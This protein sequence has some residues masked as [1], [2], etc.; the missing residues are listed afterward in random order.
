MAYYG[1]DDVFVLLDGYDMGNEI[2]EITPPDIEA[3]FEKSRGFG[4]AWDEESPIGV[5]QWS[6]GFRARYDD[7][8]LKSNVAL[9]TQVGTNRVLA[10]GLEGNAKGKKVIVCNPGQGSYGRMPQIDGLTKVSVNFVGRDR[11]EDMLILQSLAADS[12]AGAM[13]DGSTDNTT[14][15]AN[16]GRALIVVTSLTLGGYTSLTVNLR[17]SSDNGGGDPFAT[18]QALVTGL[19]GASVP[20]AAIV[21]ISGTIE[22]YTRP[23]LTWNGAGSGESVTALVALI[24]D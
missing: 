15:S 11:I 18:K 7:A 8:A 17:E 4:D 22:R 10:M 21:P 2:F 20:Y 5:K 14:S 13:P 16:G 3:L 19:V 1:P 12:G 24:R 9:V 6:C 23:E